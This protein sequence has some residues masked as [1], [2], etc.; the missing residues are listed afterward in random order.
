MSGLHIHFGFGKG[1]VALDDR[2]RLLT[3]IQKRQAHAAGRSAPCCIPPGFSKYFP[4][5]TITVSGSRIRRKTRLS[6]TLKLGCHSLKRSNSTA[7]MQT[8]DPHPRRRSPF[9]T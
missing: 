7:V 5:T 2:P 3:T 1:T 4:E 9:E 8:Y 6:F